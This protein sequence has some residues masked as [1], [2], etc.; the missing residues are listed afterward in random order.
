MGKSKWNYHASDAGTH[1]QGKETVAWVRQMRHESRSLGARRSAEFRAD[2]AK[3]EFYR[4]QIQKERASHN[5]LFHRLA[6]LLVTVLHRLH[7][8]LSNIGV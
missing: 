3:L 1:N 5:G 7:P 6:T 2:L 4:V 8:A